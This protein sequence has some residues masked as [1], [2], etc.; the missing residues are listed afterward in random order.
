MRFV[1]YALVAGFIAGIAAW[2]TFRVSPD[3]WRAMRAPVSWFAL[4]IVPFV[5]G[6]VV[7][8]RQPADDRGWMSLLWAWLATFLFTLGMNLPSLSGLRMLLAILVFVM[9]ACTIGVGAALLA[10]RRAGA[11]P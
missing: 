6:I 2:L 5:L 1:G 7:V 8:T 3:A 4:T 10:H 9:P 11:N